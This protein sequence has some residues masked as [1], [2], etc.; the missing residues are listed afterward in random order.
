MKHVIV[1]C[2]NLC[3][4]SKMICE[5]V[6][7]N[8]AFGGPTMHVLGMIVIGIFINQT[9]LGEFPGSSTLLL[10]KSN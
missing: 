1:G 4:L 3:Q 7:E 10:M 6:S 5:T 9:L 8:V 2:T